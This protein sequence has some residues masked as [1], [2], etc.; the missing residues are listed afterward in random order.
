M[1]VTKLFNIINELSVADLLDGNEGLLSEGHSVDVVIQVGDTGLVKAA[2]PRIFSDDPKTVQVIRA[3]FDL[4]TKMFAQKC[5]CEECTDYAQ[6]SYV[7]SEPK[8]VLE[9]L[10]AIGGY[11]KVTLAY[12][13][14]CVIEQ[15]E[16]EDVLEW[17]E[18]IALEILSHMYNIS[19]AIEKV[20]SE[21]LFMCL[22]VED[23]Q[24]YELK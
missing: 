5:I 4:A 17:E 2:K 1:K 14:G 23:Y 21:E 9:G 12:N 8:V 18:H 11:E 15:N 16:E 24:D 7:F 20:N 6:Q 10:T 19:S 13:K 22:P 3:A